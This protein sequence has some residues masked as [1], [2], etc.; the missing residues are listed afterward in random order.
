MSRWRFSPADGD[1]ALA[2]N[3]TTYATGSLEVPRGLWGYGIRQTKMVQPRPPAVFSTKKIT[4]GVTGDA[5]MVL[6]GETLVTVT[7]KGDLRVG[8]AL[9]TLG[10]EPVY[11]GLIAAWG[12]LY[13]CTQKGTVICIE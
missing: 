12:S 8:D 13:L 4:T 11:D 6:A 1:V 2:L 9:L 5:A 10:V 3:S 7:S